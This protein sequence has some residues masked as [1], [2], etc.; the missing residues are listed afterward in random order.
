[1]VKAVFLCLENGP[2]PLRAR[3]LEA[4]LRDYPNQV[5]ALYLLK[6][7]YLGLFYSISGLM[8]FHYV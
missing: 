5:D 3:V 7:F 4:F 6:G 8:V 1:M 2:R